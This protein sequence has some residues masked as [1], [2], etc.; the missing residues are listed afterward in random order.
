ML[1]LLRLSLKQPQPLRTAVSNLR[2]CMGSESCSL[3]TD[4]GFDF[5]DKA[6]GKTQKAEGFAV[7]MC[8]PE[9]ENSCLTLCNRVSR[10]SPSYFR[11]WS[12]F[13]GFLVEVTE[14]QKRAKKT[15]SLIELLKKSEKLRKLPIITTKM[16]PKSIIFPC[17]L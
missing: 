15:I 17:L 1:Y 4:L 11:K 12:L 5:A 2:R 10:N 13:L 3:E 9:N 14:S 16:L 8:K 7:G 6:A